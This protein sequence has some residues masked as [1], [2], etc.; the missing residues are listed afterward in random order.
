[1]YKYD[2]EYVRE[3]STPDFDPHLD[4]AIAA[5]FI[6]KDDAE[7]YKSGQGGFG[8]ER[9][10]KIHKFRYMGKTANYAA[11]YGAGPAT[12]ARGA[13]VSQ[14][15][16]EQLHTAYWQR[17]SAISDVASN[18]QIRQ[19]RGMMWLFN[20]VSKMWLY[21]KND[22]DRFSTLNQSTGT[23][24]FDRWLYHVLQER[25]QLTA[26]FHDEF[27]LEISEFESRQEITELLE[28]AVSTVNQELKLNRDLGCDINF[29][30]NYAGIH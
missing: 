14:E 8:C 13:G 27:V 16:G 12:I 29:A 30:Q 23:F 21:L 26:Q 18:V 25:E 22:K 20:P 5:G 3:M 28:S 4:M 10:S 24:C 15:L 19:S 2:P 6:D 9:W 17:N 11:T 1:M 7:Y